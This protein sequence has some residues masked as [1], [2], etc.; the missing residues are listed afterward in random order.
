VDAIEREWHAIAEGDDGPFIPAMAAV[1]VIGHVLD[2]RRPAAGARADTADVELAD[3]ELQ[4]AHRRIFTGV[5][6]RS[7]PTYTRNKDASI[8]TS[9][10][11]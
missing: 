9:I 6:E 8:S 5:R 11:A 10:S 4:F 7:K 1:A 2:G 3:Y